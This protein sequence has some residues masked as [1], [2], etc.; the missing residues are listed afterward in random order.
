MTDPGA[1]GLYIHVPFCASKCPYCD[2]FSIAA[3]GMTD[4]WCAAVCRELDLYRGS[5]PRFKTV[6][7]GGGTPSLLS[8]RQ[9]GLLMERVRTS[10]SVVGDAECTIEVNPDDMSLEKARVLRSLGF[11]RLSIGVQSFD[12]GVLGFLQ[13]RHTARQSLE[14]VEHAA[15]AGFE[16]V[17]LDLMYGLPR[18]DWQ[19]DLAQALRLQ[20][21]HL[22]CYQLT[23]KPGTVFFRMQQENSLSPESE[24]TLEQLF[25][26]ADSFLGG[27]GYQHYEVSNYARD[28]A[29]EARHNSRYWRHLPYLGLGPAAHSFD[30]HK[31]WWNVDSVQGYCR[32]LED[33]AFPLADEE[34]L[35]VEQLRLER[36]MLGLRTSRGAALADVGSDERTLAQLER[37]GLITVRSGR[38]VP[39]IR[40]MLVADRL[41]LLLEGHENAPA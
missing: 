12:D 10:V 28:A 38:V 17:S 40:G 11:N 32:L 36:L 26:F 25:L 22:S 5:F 27:A 18:Q 37:E 34:T 3:A 20:P 8:E 21:A 2:F 33:G 15:A 29:C 41:P 7:F 19:A 16:N 31:R 14:A 35:S 9:L 6:Y 13:R 1:A 39:T 4:A 23:I 30:G 24:D